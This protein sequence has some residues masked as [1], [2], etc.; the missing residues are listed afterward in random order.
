VNWDSSMYYDENHVHNRYTLEIWPANNHA[1]YCL[2]DINE[3]A[4]SNHTCLSKANCN[5]TFG[6]YNC[7]CP[8]G[9]FGNGTRLGGC[10]LPDGNAYKIV[11]PTVL[12]KQ[13]NTP[14]FNL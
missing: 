10:K 3:C 1:F 14:N 8:I 12:G 11:L 7:F 4:T 9:Q 5:N 2:S 13:Q 6:N